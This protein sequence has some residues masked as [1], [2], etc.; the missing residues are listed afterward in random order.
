[1]MV[2]IVVL[3]N[4]NQVE[5]F[6]FVASTRI[7]AKHLSKHNF[8]DRNNYISRLTG[9][10]KHLCRSSVNL[11]RNRWKKVGSILGWPINSFLV[12]NA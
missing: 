12:N 2:F 4:D 5:V 1:M 3:Y 11:V 10:S 8:L 9:I 7:W 6:F